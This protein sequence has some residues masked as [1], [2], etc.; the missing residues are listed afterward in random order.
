MTNQVL[1]LRLGGPLQAWSS[2]SRYNRRETDSI[3]TKSG[4]L[5]LLAAAQGRRRSDPIEDLLDLRMGVRVDQPGTLL[6]D[7]HTISSLAGEP[8]LSAS[9]GSQG[10]QKAT[11]PKKYTH[12]TQR[13]YLQNACFVA[14][15]EGPET[16]IQN[17]AEAVCNPAFPLFLGRRSCPPDRPP[18]LCNRT[19][20]TWDPDLHNV[21]SVV[22]W[23]GK[24]VEFGLPKR[25]ITPK[26][27]PVTYDTPDGDSEVSDVPI[28]YE[29]TSRGMR[30]RKV[31]TTWVVPPGL[32]ESCDSDSVHDP[33]DL[34]GG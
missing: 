33:F 23:Q 5:G 16:L 7:Y 25:K 6:P 31:S 13:F 4:V 26:S 2:S 11:S 29:P 10:K 34:L 14:A 12:V 28:S 21:L 3:P 24:P 8:L 30:T 27:L 20:L 22:S 9:V 32:N 18:L 17:L 1:V 19:S 15:I